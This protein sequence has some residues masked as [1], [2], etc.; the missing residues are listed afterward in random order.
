MKS[1]GDY[2]AYNSIVPE[3]L[4]QRPKEYILHCV[5]RL[6]ESENIPPSD[7]QKQ[8]DKF[9]VK[10]SDGEQKYVVRIKSATCTCFD[11][12]RY[13]RP[14][15]HMFAIFKHFPGDVSWCDLPEIFRDSIYVV[16][17]EY[18]TNLISCNVNRKPSATPVETPEN[19]DTGIVE[20]D[21]IE[22]DDT[23]NP[24]EPEPQQSVSQSKIKTV[25]D[26]LG[27][28]KNL[29]YNVV[30]NQ[31][32]DDAVGHLVE[33][34]ELL[35]N[36]CLKEAGLILNREPKQR[37][38]KSS[39]VY[40]RIP[41]KRT[42]KN[43]FSKRRGASAD[44]KKSNYMVPTLDRC[45]NKQV[46]PNR[47]TPRIVEE[48]ITLPT[49]PVITLPRI[50]EEVI[51][52]PTPTEPVELI[53][54]A[55]ATTGSTDESPVDKFI[56]KCK[57]KATSRSTD[58]LQKCRSKVTTRSHLMKFTPRISNC[59]QK[60]RTKILIVDKFKPKLSVLDLKCIE[61]YLDK[62]EKLVM[63]SIYDSEFVDGWLTDD[64]IDSFFY[65]LN[66]E[67]D[68]ILYLT[69]AQT[70][71]LMRGNKIS[72]PFRDIDISR[73]NFVFLPYNVSGNHWILLV[74]KV[75]ERIVLYL[76]P[77]RNIDC[78]KNR[79]C[80][81]AFSRIKQA[82]EKYCKYDIHDILSPDR[83]KQVDSSSCGVFVCMYAKWLCNN[84]SLINEGD[85][86]IYRESLYKYIVGNCLGRF[87]VGKFITI[88]KCLKCMKVKNDLLVDWIQ[89]VRCNQWFH[90]E[91]VSV[92]KERAP[93]LQFVCP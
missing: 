45:L 62:G 78:T 14:C 86:Y 29:V 57:S 28:L 26:L 75:K 84:E 59:Q 7:I 3:Y 21:P 68:G 70:T 93:F 89:C 50:V 82:V 1:S 53:D 9:L 52:L 77:G 44:V 31:V 20:G 64:V 39:S 46:T 25:A 90:Q 88:G 92:T 76:D 37:K 17:D 48:V 69:C 40:H 8:D 2:R 43:P 58:K 33:A 91:C 38:R 60:E 79:E 12:Q 47:V 74:I 34:K 36:G 66:K 13:W 85:A 80:K 6:L 4:Y 51:T 10:S 55:P 35:Y 16:L 5:K 63:R 15:K 27:E 71:T 83:S 56:Q 11:Y 65:T 54:E 23:S 42:R 67:Y 87:K 18:F 32:L 72:S 81:L 41:T 22:G 30:D 19:F 73:F 24:I 49:E 61:P